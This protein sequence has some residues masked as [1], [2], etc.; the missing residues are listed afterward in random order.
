MDTIATIAFADSDTTVL[1]VI[2]AT[3]SSLGL[4]AKRI[5]QRSPFCLPVVPQMTNLSANPLA[6]GPTL[7]A[8][9]H[10]VFALGWITT[11]ALSLFQQGE[12]RSGSD[13]T[14]EH[15][16][17]DGGSSK[18]HWNGD[19]VMEILL[20]LYTAGPREEGARNVANLTVRHEQSQTATH[21][22]VTCQ[23]WNVETYVSTEFVSLRASLKA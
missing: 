23:F 16:E 7:I 12:G 20:L 3:P 8:R 19:S 11:A 6:I 22:L 1:S 13:D 18:Y 15:E 10:W 14:G 4:D 21:H 17:N 9:T 2:T 5:S